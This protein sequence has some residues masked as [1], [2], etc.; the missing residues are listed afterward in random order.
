MK[1]LKNVTIATI[2]LVILFT[3]VHSYL[4]KDHRNIS[5]EDAKFK[6]E[7]LAFNNEFKTNVKTATQKYL[8]NV[9]IINGKITEID[10][11]GVVLNNEVYVQFD[12]KPTNDLKLNEKINI[13]GRCIGYDELLETVKVDQS[14]ILN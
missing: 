13:K 11:D 7:A 1:I 6:I 5:Q 2:L 10:T 4:Y 9:V 12:K 8:N 3:V 14:E